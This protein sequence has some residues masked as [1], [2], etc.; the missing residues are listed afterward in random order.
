ML[1]LTISI[2]TTVFTLVYSLATVNTTKLAPILRMYIIIIIIII[3]A[4]PNGIR[5]CS[6]NDFLLQLYLRLCSKVGIILTR[7]NRYI[8]RK[9]CSSA[10]LS[11]PSL[12][13]VC[14]AGVCFE[15]Q[16]YHWLCWD[17]SWFYCPSR[18][19]LGQ[20]LDYAMIFPIR[21][22]SKFAI[23]ESFSHLTLCTVSG[24]DIS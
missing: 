8:R 3:L 13:Y 17:V 19:D 1:H 11:A 10:T 5:W 9:T 7:E 6:G 22:F 16:T 4:F 23:Q 14:P 24:T 2:I 18:G 21:V 12:T 15:S 20:N